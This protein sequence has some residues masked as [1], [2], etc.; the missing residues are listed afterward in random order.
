[1]LVTPNA[2]ELPAAASTE[3]VLEAHKQELMDMF[4]LVSTLHVAVILQR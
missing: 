3:Q 2:E 1:M 4:G